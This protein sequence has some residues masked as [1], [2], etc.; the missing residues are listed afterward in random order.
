MS[1]SERKTKRRQ[2][3][4]T[5]L[6]K[7]LRKEMRPTPWKD[8]WELEWV[9]RGLLSVLNVPQEVT[10]NSDINDS[11]NSVLEALDRISVWTARSHA[12]EALPHAVEATASLAQI[13]W[14]DQVQTEQMQQQ[15]TQNNNG[16]H[17]QYVSVTELRLAYSSAIVR[18]IN[19]F[20]DA[21]Q[22]Q[23]FVAAPVSM[24]CGQLGIPSWLVDIRH[25]SSHNALP[26]LPILRLATVTLLEYLQSEYWIP[27]CP[28]WVGADAVDDDEKQQEDEQGESPQEG[29][30]TPGTQS[31]TKKGI[32]ILLQYKAC[33]SKPPTTTVL[34]SEENTTTAS[35]KG[36][37]DGKSSNRKRSCS[38]ASSSAANR[39]LDNFF[40]NSDNGS[41]DDDDDDD[42]DEGDDW[43]D[44]LL[45]SISLFG[46]SIGT[47]HNRFAALEAPTKAKLSS[48]ATKPPKVKKVKPPQRKKQAGEKYPF[49]HAKEFIEAVSPQEGFS[50]AIQF[51]V[52]GGIGG[53]AP[54]RGVLIPG[55]TVAFP[56]TQQG[57][58]KSWQRYLPLIEVLG[59]F[60][61]GFCAALLVHLVDFVV[62]VEDTCVEQG[63]EDP[64]SVRKMFFL[65]SWIRLLVSEKFVQKLYPG[66]KSSSV[67]SNNNKGKEGNRA[68]IPL[69][70]Y[71]NMLPLQYPLNSLC[72]RCRM[73]EQQQHPEL[74]KASQDILQ[75]FEEILNSK[76][77]A[78]YGIEISQSLPPSS[79]MAGPLPQ[80]SHSPEQQPVGEIGH[81]P[82]LSDGKMSL[83]E[84]EALFSDDDDT[85]GS[86]AGKGTPVEGPMAGPQM[87]TR[88]VVPPNRP[89]AWTRCTA[90]DGCAIGTMPGQPV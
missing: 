50:T 24:L 82:A 73:Y 15:Q 71:E 90:W 77:I 88:S 31:S 35:T 43:E 85:A 48:P 41:S 51:L 49:D 4:V 75:T 42:D 29:N 40:G 19:G 1:T 84:M 66:S 52:W 14:R 38:T 36:A 87:E 47:T 5:K 58:R 56:A 60:W 70:S 12:M 62:S 28:Q 69:A 18:C 61:P 53:S 55:S 81:G 34:P 46:S 2:D 23:R 30:N 45:G 9:G 74:H 6:N 68:E 25:E 32:D 33:A 65:S 79:L 21:L 80:S 17:M 78:D 63:F 59:R 89:S 44:P 37:E 67:N 26:T 11:N 72:D 64:G 13:Y 57:I 83:D 54:G 8:V 7:R 76:R 39:P 22:Q 86:G 20:A 27:T 10:N 16:D 3:N